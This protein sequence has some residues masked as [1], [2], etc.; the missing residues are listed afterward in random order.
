MKTAT[1]RQLRHDFGSVLA[2]LEEGEEVEIKK[3]GKVVARMTPPRPRKGGKVQWPDIL[4]RLKSYCG[5]F[6]LSDKALQALLD[7]EEYRP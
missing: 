6:V 1:V 2:W 5:D 7:R 3:R 4:A